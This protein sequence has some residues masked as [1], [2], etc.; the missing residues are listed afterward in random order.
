MLLRAGRF[1]IYLERSITRSGVYPGGI[2]LKAV[3]Y[4]EFNDHR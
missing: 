1:E 4:R 3:F 2:F